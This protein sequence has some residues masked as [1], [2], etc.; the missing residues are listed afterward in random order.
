[1]F[2]VGLIV[3]GFVGATVGFFVAAFC[4]MSKIG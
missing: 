4:A 3:G 2:W 1:M